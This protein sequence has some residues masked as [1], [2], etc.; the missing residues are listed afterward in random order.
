MW[1]QDAEWLS[2]E[3]E[4][5]KLNSIDSTVLK[6]IPSPDNHFHKITTNEFSIY[7]SPNQPDYAILTLEFN[8]VKGGI[9]PELKSLKTYLLQYRD[10]IM[11][12]ERAAT[13]LKEHLLEMYK[14]SRIKVILEFNTRGG[15]AS[16]IVVGGQ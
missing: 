14:P 11:S 2:E 3:D 16:E 4:M 13:I 8:I 6:S 12:Y 7:G 5:V 10:C 1:W 15:L 9:C